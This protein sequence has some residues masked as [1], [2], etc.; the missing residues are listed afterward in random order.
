MKANISAIERGFEAM[1]ALASIENNAKLAHTFPS[2]NG[3]GKLAARLF[4]CW[5][6]NM[7]RPFSNKDQAYRTCLD[8]GA[9]RRFNVGS[10]EMQG[11]FYYAARGRQ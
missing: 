8:C 3:I 5:H 6:K 7:S 9:S 4:G 1:Q 2:E 10:W 11:E